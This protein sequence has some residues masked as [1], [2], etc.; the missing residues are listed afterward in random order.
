MEY[1]LPNN[2]LKLNHLKKAKKI[3][4]SILSIFILLVIV[5]YFWGSASNYDSSG[6]D[7]IMV[8]NNGK[9]PLISDTL[10][11][12]TYN[13]GYLSGMSNN[14]PVIRTEKLFSD[15]LEKSKQLFAYIQPDFIGFQEIDFNA[16]R[17]YEVNQMEEFANANGYNYA[18]MAVNWDKKYVPFPYGGP[19]V[20]FG[21]IYSG[22][23]IVSKYPILSN[24]L[25]IL[26]KPKSH[27]FYYNAFYL[28][29]IA[30]IDAID[31]NGK[32]V[33]LI[34][35]HMEAFDV[36]TRE[37][38]A[39][40]LIKIYQEYANDYPVLL[41][42]DFNST[43]PNATQPY[44]DETTMNMIFSVPGLKSAISDSLY[45]SDEKAYFTYDSE[46]PYLKIDYIF[47]NSDKVEAID[48]RIVTEAGEI[49]DHLPVM[50]S[51]VLK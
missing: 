32:K 29:R 2:S 21:Q 27:A 1:W 43:P 31:I 15:N 39:E 25:K 33:I 7:D 5:F 26:R 3:V 44:A 48:G 16:K 14:L 51:F 23:A 49:S 35:V 10:R 46:T 8:Y 20:H 37:K 4:F 47:Y 30:Q 41:F 19:N 36:P 28:D 45:L 24:E 9:T 18:A 50:L 12:L 17:S 13:L 40:T 42:G 38:Q 34:N 6:Y 11:V 22:Q